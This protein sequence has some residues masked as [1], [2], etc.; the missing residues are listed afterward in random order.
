MFWAPMAPVRAVA[1][2]VL[3]GSVL[4]PLLLMVFDPPRV[5]YLRAYM[6][7]GS[8]VSIGAVRSKISERDAF[9]QAL[10]AQA[11]QAGIPTR[12]DGQADLPRPAVGERGPDG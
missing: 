12:G 6:A 2:Y 9:Y 3:C 8:F 1:P 5:D 11:G 10:M 7:Q 4:A